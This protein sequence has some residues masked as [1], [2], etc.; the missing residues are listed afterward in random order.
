MLAANNRVM[1]WGMA[2]VVVSVGVAIALYVLLAGWVHENTCYEVLPTPPDSVGL[3]AREQPELLA[4]LNAEYASSHKT[5]PGLPPLDDAALP[6]PV[7]VTSIAGKTAT[8]MLAGAASNANFMYAA[9][10]ARVWGSHHGKPASSV[11]F[12][13]CVNLSERWDGGEITMQPYPV[14]F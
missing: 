3:I 14:M 4:A 6:K 11:K 13:P 10:W 12:L 9:A 2:A 7:R 1:R 8:V 5:I